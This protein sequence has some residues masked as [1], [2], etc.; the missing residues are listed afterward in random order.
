MP[1][2]KLSEDERK[3]RHRLCE[4]RRKARI[5][6]DPVL[7]ERLLQKDRELYARKKAAGLIIPRREMSARKL[8]NLRRKNL[9]SAKAYYQRNKIKIKQAKKISVKD[10]DSN[11]YMESSDANL[12]KSNDNLES[13]NANLEPTET[14]SGSKQD[15][16]VLG[17]RRKLRFGSPQP[18]HRRGENLRINA[19]VASTSSF[20]ISSTP[21]QVGFS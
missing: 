12:E 19:L 1:K 11:P 15:R 5:K 17:S 10:K 9:V 20:L 13:S 7:R 4:R 18:I 14:E 16:L 8:I 2:T 3:E 6:S 21:Q